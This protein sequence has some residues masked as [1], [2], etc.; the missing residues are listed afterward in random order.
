[1]RPV[2]PSPVSTP[3]YRRWATDIV[4]L[5][6]KPS[7]RLASCWSVLVVNGAA[8]LRVTGRVPVLSTTGV[9]VAQGGGMDLGAL[10]LGDLGR[11]AVDADEVGGE[12]DALGRAQGDL[13]RPVLAGDEAP[14]LALA[15]D[16]DADGDG[17]DPTGRQ[18]AADLARQER[19]ERVAD[20]PV[21]DPPRLLGVD[22]VRVDLARVG[23]RVA[24]GAAGDL[25]EGDPLRLGGIHVGRLG[26]VPG[27]RLP[28]PVEVG[29][30]VD[31]VGP[32]G[33]LGDLVDLLAPI[34]GDHV[35]GREVVV[36]VHAELALAGVLGEVPDVTV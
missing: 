16:D 31:R 33:G 4:R 13:D 21:D 28:F 15:V 12:R 8:G 11:L 22:E 30:Q 35:L 6:L 24:D 5:G 10:A 1:M 23:E 34:V 3:S 20:E 18:A 2:W 9:D 27:D 17:L 14:D 7:L 29:R 36:D 25:V 26:D 32:L 19:A